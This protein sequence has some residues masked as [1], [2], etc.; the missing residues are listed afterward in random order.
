MAERTTS[1]HGFGIEP[2][3]EVPRSEIH[4]QDLVK[5]I[6]SIV[7]LD[8]RASA[9]LDEEELTYTWTLVET[10]LGSLVT[11]LDVVEEDGSVVSLTPD[12]TGAYVV[13]L[14]VSTPY[15]TSALAT[16]TVEIQAAVVPYTA[17]ITPD[18]SF[19]FGIISDFW[20]LVEDKLVFETLWSGYIQSASS[21]LL[22]LFQVD[23]AKSIQSIQLLFQR[24][25]LDYSPKLDLEDFALSGVFGHE[26]SGNT[27]FTGSATDLGT[28]LIIS[29]REFLLIE[30]SPSSDAIGTTLRVFSSLG[31]PGNVASYTINRI[32]PSNTGYIVSEATPFP[33]PNDEIVVGGS[34][35]VTFQ[36]NPV[37]FSNSIDVVAAGVL[38]GDF[39]HIV[40]G[41]DAGYYEILKVG[42]PDGLANDR[43]LELTSL[44][45]TTKTNLTFTVLRTVR[46]SFQRA[47]KANTDT[48]YIPEGDADLTLYETSTFAGNG[49]IES[50]F[51]LV[52]EA[53]HVFDAL[54]GKTIKVTSGVNGGVTFTIAGVNNPRTGY[55]IGANFVGD[56]P[57]EVSYEIPVVADITSRVLVL[58]GRAHGILSGV[59]DI[60]QPSVADGGKGPLWVITLESETAPA[61]REGLEWRIANSLIEADTSIDFEEHGISPNDRL[62]LTVRRSDSQQ[63]STIPCTVLGAVGNKISF[64]VGTDP[65]GIHER[66]GLNDSETFILAMELQVPLVTVDPVTEDL[67][68]TG[69]ALEIQIL[70]NSLSFKTDNYNLPITE[71]TEISLDSFTVTVSPDHITR[72]CRIPVDETVAS[73]PALFEYIAKPEIGEDADGNI[74]LVGRDFSEKILSDIPVVFLENRDFTVG[75]EKSIKGVNAQTSAGSEIITLPMADLRDRDVRI[76][77]DLD[78]LSGFDQDRYNILEVL[79]DETVRVLSLAGEIPSNDAVGLTYAIIRRT[80]GK[81]LRFVEGMFSPGNPAPDRLWAETTFFDN[82]PYIDD[83]FGSLVNVSKEQ[84]DE[85]GSSQVSYKGAVSGLMYAWT[86]GPTLLNAAIGSH[87]L[88]GLPVTEV[89]GEVIDVNDEYELGRGRIMIED[90]DRD[91]AKT[92]LVRIYFYVPESA[93][94]FAF[95]GLSTNPSTGRAWEI[96]DTIPPFTPI[97]N[98]VIVEDYVANPTWWQIGGA[99]GA[100]ELKKYHTWQASIDVLQ[101]DSRDIG[102]V[103]DYLTAIRPMQTKPE[104]IASLYLLD[105]VTVVDAFRIEGT[106]HLFDDPAFSLESTHMVDS[107]F[108]GSLPTRILDVGSLATRTLFRG[109]DL[110]MTAGSATVS[111][112]RGGFVDEGTLPYI[113]KHFEDEV[114]VLGVSL[115]RPGDILYI[116]FGP[117]RGR[118]LITAITDD[119]T[120][121]VAIYPTDIPPRTMDPAQFEDDD[122]QNFYIQRLDQNPLVENL[123][124][125]ATTSGDELTDATGNFT[126]NGVSVDDTVV[127]PSGANKGLYRVSL[128]GHKVLGELE[129]E[130]TILTVEPPFPSDIATDYYVRREALRVN[131]L[132]VGVGGVTVG[133]Q[134]W[135][136]TTTID[137]ELDARPGDRM[138]VLS[139]ADDGKTFGV[140]YAL[141]DSIWTD[142]PFSATEAAVSIEIYR[143]LLGDTHD[144]D[145]LF[146]KLHAEDVV[147]LEIL[148]PRVIFLSVADLTL[149]VDDATSAGTDLAAAGVTTAMVMQVANAHI[150]SGVYELSAVSG[151]TVTTATEFPLDETPVSAD[152]L[153]DDPDFSIAGTTVTSVG[154]TNYETLGVRPGDVLAILSGE[155]TV[156]TVSG[157]SFTVT[158]AP[159]AGATTGKIIRRLYPC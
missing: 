138:R 132:L 103:S 54:V 104:I 43:S 141:G 108:H 6:G 115:V 4:P 61:G 102:L 135:V 116:V 156:V 39:L 71:T 69:Q 78:L 21:D 46:A 124:T 7:K 68:I 53:R 146:E 70:L 24:R 55:I 113:N 25:W 76:G 86:T 45:T 130:D 44:P 109:D 17:Q 143:P 83:N 63:K 122:L 147:T 81:Y 157:T 73:V 30:N 59:L 136:S 1:S 28:G 114:T 148:R 26:Q 14:T 29:P 92:G 96:G 16:T 67:S 80:P 9:S 119:E 47:A 139:G 155:F 88:L 97:S 38:P 85:F 42:T 129:D 23:Y 151:F 65:K 134:E 50:I 33:A 62:S 58:D 19:I 121:E 31:V 131:P 127:V 84:L 27:A 133:G 158:S 13:G 60:A 20:S 152:F 91:G 154:G 95:A 3:R 140:I 144:S 94:D 10:P 51:E 15:R 137:S 35:L 120:L 34:D 112:A 56:F 101:I 123:S 105:E 149:V 93:G 111:S 72:N 41:S 110:A 49:T 79:D 64:L 32:N 118:Y 36:L 74:I 87:L 40:S 75:S 37:V 99:T 8:G 106:I 150:S 89:L 90:L 57:Q 145:F 82:S 48:V 22:R 126:W 117:N 66:E 125:T 107:S 12:I 2:L 5:V 11:S 153:D 77:D 128:V 159:P 18:A 142:L 52:V 100:D 98:G